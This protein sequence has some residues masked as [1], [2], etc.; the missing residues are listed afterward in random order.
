M[1]DVF[2]FNFTVSTRSWR[3]GLSFSFTSLNA[4]LFVCGDHVVVRSKRLPIPN[5]MVEIQDFGCLFGKVGIS[6]K[7]PTPITPGLDGV[8]TQPA[9]DCGSTYRS[10]NTTLNSFSSDI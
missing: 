2:S 6:G 1:P 9:P 7:N 10:G 8:S 4:G 3:Q 5:T